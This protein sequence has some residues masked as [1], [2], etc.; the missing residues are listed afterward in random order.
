MM[1]AGR[2]ALKEA[3]L[4]LLFQAA[5]RAKR[6]G[7]FAAAM[8]LYAVAAGHGHSSWE[9]YD[10]LS[11][12]EAFCGLFAESKRSERAAMRIL[13]RDVRCDPRSADFMTTVASRFERYG[14]YEAALKYYR[15]AIEMKTSYFT[16]SCLK[17]GE[18]CLWLGRPSRAK[19]WARLALTR[20]RDSALAR[21]LLG[22]A[23]VLRREYADAIELLDKSVAL[24]PDDS[25]SYIWRSEA[26]RML[27]RY[28]SAMADLD[29]AIALQ[30][31]SGEPAGAV[32]NRSLVALACGESL[33]QKEYELL[34]SN[35][36]REVADL[37]PTA[38]SRPS[39]QLLAHRLETAL[40]RMQ[41]NRSQT[42]TY[43][44]VIRGKRSLLRFSR[45]DDGR[46]PSDI[47]GRI[48]RMCLLGQPRRALMEYA[49]LI[50]TGQATPRLYAYRGEVHS[51][52][53]EYFQAIDDYKKALSLNGELPWPFIGLAGAHILLGEFLSA[54]DFLGSAVENGAQPPRLWIRR[55]EANYRLGNHEA[56]LA[57]LRLATGGQRFAPSAW[58]LR[59]LVE[60]AAGNAQEQGRLFR[61]TADK[62][63]GFITAAAGC[64]E[65]LDVRAPELWTTAERTQVLEEALRMM[66][67]NRSARDI[68]TYVTPT[69][70]MRGIF[71]EDDLSSQSRAAAKS[72]VPS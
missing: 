51:W 9:A 41:G 17:S 52:M 11:R 20:D 48:Q 35:I 30:W 65:A 13:A 22:A 44:R 14:E 71:I 16:F 28:T 63:P 27:K 31:G 40:K 67:G 21:R 2:E 68:D 29:S 62:M 39:A 58:I 72:E 56:A 36:P 42:T 32:I 1:G 37:D 49:R 12:L 45:T 3:G 6:Q 5:E 60:G 19:A 64:V 10:R 61:Q 15:R 66:R 26:K 23:A 4:G 18:L 69:G 59:T 55:A 33:S 7:Q 50:K 38:R 47:Y 24:R 70:Q 54:L 34:A 57:D 25:E 53:G 8:R 43:V 46:A